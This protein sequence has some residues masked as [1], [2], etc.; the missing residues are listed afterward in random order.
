MRG[1]THGLRART[2]IT[3]ALVIACH[4][5]AEP[6]GTAVPAVPAGPTDLVAYGGCTEVWLEPRP[7]CLFVPTTPLR[8]WLAQSD[9]SAVT[10]R[11]DGK[12]W[13]AEHRLVDGTAGFGLDV[14]LPPGASELVAEFTEPHATWSLPLRTWSKGMTPL[15]G[16]PTNSTVDAALGRAFTASWEGRHI[17]ALRLLAE[18]EP[19]AKR[20]PKGQADLATYRGLT[21][22]RQGR[23][24]DAATSLADGVVFGV[25]MHDP[26]LI[27]DAVPVYAATVAELGYWDAAGD[28]ADQVLRLV[29]TEP[30]LFPCLE[31]ARI[32][33]TLGYIHLRLAR[34]QGTPS[35]RAR[36]LLEQ[37][38]AAVGPAGECPE[39]SAVPA[40]VLS[41]ADEA[42]DRGEASRALAFLATID[43]E[44][45]PT[46]DQR[47]RLRDVELRAL[48]AAGRSPTELEP[49]LALLEREVLDAELPEGRWR[50]AL[51]RGD[52]FAQEHRFDEAIAAYRDAER[53][54]HRIAELAAVG[55]GRETAAAL[56]GESTER[57]VGL[58]AEQ[59]RPDQALCAARE[60]QA[61]RIQ[62]VARTAMTADQRD[63]LDQAIERYQSARRQLDETRAKERLLPRKERDAL[64]LQ[65]AA[66]EQVLAKLANDILRERPTWNPSC[67]D[68]IP[69]R[70]GEL[71]LGLYP[72]RRRWFV[73]VQD[74]AGTLVHQLDGG[75]THTLDDPVLGSELL[76][77][78]GERIATAKRIRV[79]ASG[80]AQG[81]DVHLLSWNGATLV[82]HAPVAYGAELPRPST[83]TS[84]PAKPIALLLADPTETLPMASKEVRKAIEWTRTRTWIP[85]VPTPDQADRSHVLRAL[86]RA[87]FFY[88]AG[89]G[90]HEE[91]EARARALPPYAGGTRDWPAH[92]LLKPPSKL[93]IPD[94]LMLPSA[95][96]HV[97]L[98]GCETGVPGGSGSGMS[99]ALAF[100]VAGAEQVVATPE[101]TTESTAAATGQG[102]LEGMSDA[103][104]D[105]AVG[106]RSA[107]V[108]MLHRG[109]DLGRY[110]V[111]VR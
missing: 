5:D 22:W 40:V 51:W 19:L 84:P 94:I 11:V 105:L 24:F 111:W 102:L 18:I 93:E 1:A 45:A 59:G 37:A 108:A 100:L 53:E 83:A 63:A 31:R 41:L 80:R 47:L 67:K 12:P 90:E 78:V 28:W 101:K 88:F 55:M 86:A 82:E 70:D 68:L 52:L 85:E 79:L 20:Y 107:Q 4:R 91:R 35:T 106:L 2:I 48:Q 39:P 57:L 87:S 46:A 49:S 56:H 43:I 77:P 36:F 95:P 81:I 30:E 50:L 66:Q 38:L 74:E 21:Y 103:D 58:L 9:A 13:P 62:G 16:T 44:A 61:R 7:R 76:D 104:I 34:W 64:R 65:V 29:R 60:A 92:L 6:T 15:P 89:H 10:L 54:S 73:F 69:V 72:G 98:L 25:R 23:F 97:A 14:L 109:Q 96:R 32:T 75:P 99:L 3:V 26:E 8:L 33:S 27:R 17:E 110:R 42:L 71:L